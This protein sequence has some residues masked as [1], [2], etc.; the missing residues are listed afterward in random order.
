MTNENEY[1]YFDNILIYSEVYYFND[2]SNK[3]NEKK[4]LNRLKNYF[5]EFGWESKIIR[6]DKKLRIYFYGKYPKLLKSQINQ[7]KKYKKITDLDSTQLV[8]PSKSKMDLTDLEGYLEAF[9]IIYSHYIYNLINDSGLSTSKRDDLAKYTPFIWFKGVSIYLKFPKSIWENLGPELY[10]RFP[11]DL[12]YSEEYDGFDNNLKNTRIKIIDNPD[13]ELMELE[14]ILRFSP[15]ERYS[16]TLCRYLDELPNSELYM[17]INKIAL[18]MFRYIWAG[19]YEEADKYLTDEEKG[20]YGNEK[21]LNKLLVLHENLERYREYQRLKVLTSRLPSRYPSYGKLSRDKG[22]L[23]RDLEKDDFFRMCTYCQ[24][25][26][27]VFE[28]KV[29]TLKTILIDYC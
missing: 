2:I 21:T 22:L 24:K 15:F 5:R 13:P 23:R 11:E 20:A 7:I 29:A 10:R 17:G 16:L 27:R 28:L 25:D 19:E 8:D 26:F 4:I 14:M 6:D 18:K 9:S 1:I 12:A 3:L